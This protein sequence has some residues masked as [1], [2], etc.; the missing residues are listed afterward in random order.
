[1]NTEH[2]IGKRIKKT[3]EDKGMTQARL[4]AATQ[5]SITQLSGYENGKT[6]SLTNLAKISQALE[7]TIDSLYFGDE[8]EAFIN[9]AS[10]VGHVVVNCLT[11]LYRLGVI[12]IYLDIDPKRLRYE[13][14]EIPPFPVLSIEKYP[15][16]IERLLANYGEIS[17]HI[18]TYEDPSGFIKQVKESIAKEISL[19]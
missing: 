4:A 13:T 10:D 16:A 7:T 15:H 6:P 8:S 3:R 12:G 1:M 11:E 2:L 9:E 5:I 17:E 19:R 14:D 18:K